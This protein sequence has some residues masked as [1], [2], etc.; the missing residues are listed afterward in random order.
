MSVIG[1]IKRWQNSPYSHPTSR[2]GIEQA[3]AEH[4]PYIIAHFM[5]MWANSLPY[6]MQN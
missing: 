4:P 1:C 6:P 3:Q 5:R 2:E